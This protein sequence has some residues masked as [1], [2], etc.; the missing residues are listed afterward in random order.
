ALPTLPPGFVSSERGCKKACDHSADQRV[1]DDVID[2]L[3]PGFHP[4]A[5]KADLIDRGED[6]VDPADALAFFVLGCAFVDEVKG[7]RCF[8]P[9][10]CAAHQSPWIMP[11]SIRRRLKRRAS[12]PS[13]QA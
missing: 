4:L 3:V 10:P 2:A 7:F 12:A 13:R 6:A 9:I 11:A 8:K 5:G 1:F